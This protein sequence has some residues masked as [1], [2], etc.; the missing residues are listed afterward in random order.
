[1]A[2]AVDLDA[3]EA[4]LSLRDGH[5]GV[6]REEAGRPASPGYGASARD[7]AASRAGN[8]SGTDPVYA[9]IRTAPR[10]SIS[11][12][13][14]FSTRERSRSGATLAR[15]SPTSPPSE[16]ADDVHRAER[17]RVEQREHV[18]DILRMV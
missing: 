10:G 14:S 12:P 6:A 3:A 7:A 4:R 13:T 16:G 11:G 1:M 17:E 2:D 5:R 8:R 9:A 18:R 15:E